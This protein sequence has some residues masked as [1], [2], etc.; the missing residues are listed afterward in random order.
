[1]AEAGQCVGTSGRVKNGVA[2]PIATRRDSD[3]HLYADDVLGGE[4][5]D[6]FAISLRYSTRDLAGGC[7]WLGRVPRHE[8]E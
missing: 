2:G 4:A 8:Q 5:I 6:S 3:P 7:Q 1:M